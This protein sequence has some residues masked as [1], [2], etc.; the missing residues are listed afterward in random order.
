MS[1]GDLQD[2]FWGPV[3][4]GCSHCHEE[5]AIVSTIAGRAVIYLGMSCLG[6]W[7]G[8]RSPEW[9]DEWIDRQTDIYGYYA[10]AR[11]IR[12]RNRDEGRNDPVPEWRY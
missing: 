6:L 8:G 3:G 1:L 5:V 10:A 7:W 12:K 2:E 9:I 4:M 11:A